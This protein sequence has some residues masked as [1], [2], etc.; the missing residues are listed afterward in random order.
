MQT[1]K[2]CLFL[3]FSLAMIAYTG[4]WAWGTPLVA[5]ARASSLLGLEPQRVNPARL[6]G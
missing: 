2:S 6:R 5:L 3:C 1:V 4:I